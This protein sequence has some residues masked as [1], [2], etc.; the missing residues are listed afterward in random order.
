MFHAFFLYVIFPW[1]VLIFAINSVAAFMI[2]PGVGDS[3]GFYSI[4]VITI[5]LIT[6]QGR[7]LAIG[8]AISIIAHTQAI[9]GKRYNR[10]DPVR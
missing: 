2:S 10:W 1:S 8:V 5:V 4:F 6:H 9:L 3:W 7:S